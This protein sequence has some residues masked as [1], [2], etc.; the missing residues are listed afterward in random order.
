MSQIKSKG[1]R[2]D[3]EEGIRLIFES[4]NPQWAMHLLCYHETQDTLA[5][6]GVPID[7]MWKAMKEIADAESQL[8]R[9]YVT[10]C[11]KKFT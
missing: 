5:Y 4:T 6:C 10:V 9:G 11:P 2:Y 1:L 7:D 8:S 3:S